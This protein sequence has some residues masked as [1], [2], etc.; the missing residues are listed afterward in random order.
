MSRFFRAL[1][2][3]LSERSKVDFE[4]KLLTTLT[5]TLVVV[6]GFQYALTVRDT[7]QRLMDEAM[8]RAHSDVVFVQ[9]AFLSGDTND[10]SSR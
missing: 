9:Q 6:G 7:K 1:G 8:F 4:L 3:I 2:R 5:L 10:L